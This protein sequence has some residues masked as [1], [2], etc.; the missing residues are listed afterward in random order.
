[1]K[2]QVPVPRPNHRTDLQLIMHCGH[3][4]QLLLMLLRQFLQILLRRLA[5]LAKMSALIL[6]VA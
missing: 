5:H 2:H 1:M 3:L 4:L 6:C